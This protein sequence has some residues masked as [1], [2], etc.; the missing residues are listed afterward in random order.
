MILLSSQRSHCDAK[1]NSGVVDR[2]K[3]VG[4]KRMNIM[5]DWQLSSG[6]PGCEEEG[7]SSNR[8]SSLCLGVTLHPRDKAQVLFVRQS[9]AVEGCEKMGR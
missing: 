8:T 9:S 2:S 3:G 5:Y 6:N 1:K 4:Q 7:S